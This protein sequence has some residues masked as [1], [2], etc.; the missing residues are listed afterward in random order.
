MNPKHV[1]E[2]AAKNHLEAETLESITTFYTGIENETDTTSDD[3]T[4]AATKTRP[5]VVLEAEGDPQEVAPFTNNWRSVLS[6]NVEA[7]A[8]STTRTALNTIC[9]EVFS[10]FGMADAAERMTHATDGFHC[11][12]MRV[13]SPATE[14]QRQEKVW[15]CSMKLEVIFAPADL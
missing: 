10:K 8:D 2:T 15:V 4:E 14:F 3:A 6:V 1:L 9:A 5:C 12:Q 11:Y 13:L 7:S